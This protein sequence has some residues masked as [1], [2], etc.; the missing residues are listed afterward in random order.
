MK[1][2]SEKKKVK[3]KKLVA[4]GSAK[5]SEQTQLAPPEKQEEA[6]HMSEA[7]TQKLKDSITNDEAAKKI[8]EI[9]SN[10]KEG[11]LNPSINFAENKINYPLLSELSN[12]NEIM[13]KL[14]DLSSSSAG[15]LEK[16]VYERL[17]VCPDHPDN[18]STTVRL[19]CSS[20][21][22]DDIAKLHLVEHKAC[23]YITDQK[24]FFAGKGDVTKCISCKK[25]IKNPEKEIQKLGRWYECN[26]CNTKFDNCVVKLHC[27][28]FNH[29]FAV[30]QAEMTTIPYY[31]IKTDSKE[32]HGYS[33]SLMSPLKKIIGA[34]GLVVDDS[35]S[36]KGKSGVDHQVSLFA[37]KGEE[38]VLFDIQGSETQIE[39]SV[40]N[41]FMLKVL[42]IAPSLSIFIGIPS[43]SDSAKTL[44]D[45]Y[46]ISVVTG[47]DFTKIINEVE[48]IIKE[49]TS[50]V[51][52]PQ[53]GDVE[54]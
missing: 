17:P 22:S 9:I 2:F 36:V 24:I 7:E 54:N 39:D 52:T 42:D 40:V 1:F 51:V 37:K 48:R 6:F 38:T 8:I 12:E 27:R 31:K 18:F 26:K 16:G 44:A 29:D 47:T 28:Q 19:Y 50:A 30:I 11:V 53:T 46:K 23:G 5:P 41:A 10:S 14:E 21:L 25:P 49:K 3:K 43:I 35:T 32:L 20:C 45:T 15:I 13:A 34:Q 4:S 33:Y